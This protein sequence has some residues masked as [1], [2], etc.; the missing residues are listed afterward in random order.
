[1]AAPAAV[2][3]SRV[4]NNRVPAD[5][6]EADMVAEVSV[7][8]PDIE[9][10]QIEL[11]YTQAVAA[12]T[13]AFIL[14]CLL[15]G[16]LWAVADHTY[17]TLW[18]VAQSVQTLGRLVLVLRYR[19][20]S[21][22]D[23]AAAK[24]MLLFFVGTLVSG[25]VWGSLGLLFSFSWPVEYQTLTLLSL[26]GIVSGA[27]SSY[28]AIMSIYIAF[29]VPCIL[30]PA[31]TML[32]YSSSLQANLG[33]ILMLFA[34]VLVIIA[35][36][37]NRNV[38]RS[39][40]LGMENQSLVSSMRSANKTLQDEIMARECTQKSL[41]SEQRLFT[42]G[43]VTVYR[44]A[45]TEGWPIEYI[46]GTVSQ[47]GYSAIELMQM[48]G[49]YS[50]IVYPDDRQRVK[51]AWALTGSSGSGSTG[52]DYRIKCVDGSARWVYDYSVPVRDDSG[53]ITHHSGYLLDITDR[54]SSEYELQQE[55]E[56]AEV[57]LYSIAEAVVTTDVNGQIEYLNPRAEELTGWECEMA[58]GLS[59][60]R[61]FSLFD[62][63]SQAFIEEPFSESLRTAETLSS[64]SDIVLSRNDGQKYTIRYSASPIMSNAG[65]PLGVILIFHDVTDTRNMERQLSY[66]ATHDTLTGLLNRSEFEVQ[67]GHAI[68]YAGKSSDEH[69]L[70]HVDI[71]QLKIVNDTGS[72]EAGDELL[73]RFS[74]LLKDCLR[75]SDAIARL[76]GDEFGALLKSCTVE[77]AAILAA[78]ILKSVKEMRFTSGDRVFEISTSIGMTQ[79]S[80][81]SRGATHVMSEANLAC[82]AAK[83]L[84]G[85]RSHVYR[86]SDA[87]LMRR[88]DEMQWVSKIAEAIKAD[89]LVLYYQTIAPVVPVNDGSVHFEVLVRMLDERGELI[90]PDKF[91]PAAE[92]YNLII[93]IDRWV[94]S[95]S[96]AWYSEH[97]QGAD[98]QCSY[99]MAIN[100][101]GTSITDADLHRHI[102]NEMKK[103]A[104]PPGSICFEVTETAAISNLSAASDFIND[105]R[106]LGCRFALDDFGS[107]LSSF[108]YLKNLPVDYLKI[109]GSFV[110]DM[111]IDDVNY[112]MVSAI[113]Q[114]GKIIGIKT[115]AEFVENDSIMGMLS[116]LGVDYAQGYAISRPQP[117]DEFDIEALRSA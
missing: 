24:W 104:I 34:G 107:G 112:A 114:L 81:Q 109:D 28:A 31:Q 49:F 116:D 12:I 73:R 103:Y 77:S 32:I 23:R 38:V 82:Q 106:K 18:L 67:L 68:E 66:A 35:R 93:G 100:L 108:G 20:A 102:K 96:F 60:S 41:V 69:V 84:G 3:D 21:E 2:S 42:N 45:V 7:F 113:Q 27:I 9:G 33:L 115:I 90:M 52:I 5:L 59:V 92:R 8:D 30:I 79:I 89:R 39:L 101:S 40:Q 17:L 13:A 94:I 16:G 48:K 6:L 75:D 58:R 53:N 65:T 87:E 86:S 97:C 83:D 22:Q 37:Y 54:K 47:F 56:R 64:R 74:A 95:H 51:D 105:L 57:T 29:M 14:A 76:G 70:F 80:A 4:P 72:H 19:R 44:C 117:L 63:E 111:D 36:N 98:G 85:N 43:P 55:K 10:Q 61:V 99:T 91:L 11:I 78:D 71:D 26:A 15:A 46:S 1:V 25:I 50:E 62:E 110:R 88:H